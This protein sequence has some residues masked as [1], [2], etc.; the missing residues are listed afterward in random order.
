MI[1]DDIGDGGLFCNIWLSFAVIN[2]L[3][4]VKNDDNDD[5]DDNVGYKYFLG[6]IWF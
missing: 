3:S 1:D 5:D 4:D 2:R 6:N